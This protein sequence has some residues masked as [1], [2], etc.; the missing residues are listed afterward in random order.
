MN[1]KKK[2]PKA[3]T[4]LTRIELLLSAVLDECYDIEKGVEKNVRALL[5]S[6]EGSIAAAKDYFIAPEAAKVARKIAKRPAHVIAHRRV[7]G[8]KAKASVAAKK[9]R[10]GRVARKVA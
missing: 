8:K 10:F 1:R 3:V 7:V 6:A 5:R 4:L 2:T 9:P